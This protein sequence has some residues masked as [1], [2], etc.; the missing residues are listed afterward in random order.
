MNEAS[1]ETLYQS[2]LDGEIS[3]FDQLYQRYRPMLYTFLMRSTRSHAEADEI[4]Q[5]C[6]S[7][8]IEGREKRREGNIENLKAY[9]FQIARNLLIDHQRK[10]NIRRVD[11]DFPLETF[12]DQSP[13]VERQ[14][15]GEDCAEILLHEVARLPDEQRESFLL[16]EEAGFTLEQIAQ[17]FKV[18]R[19]TIKSR[20]RYTMQK[21]RTALEG[22]L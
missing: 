2:Y 1:D 9:L 21:L 15:D 14:R 11:S 6:W 8:L 22:C 7:R 16:K 18:G 4:Y 5:E 12:E 10:Q 3:A 17:H 19:E 20:L 13:S